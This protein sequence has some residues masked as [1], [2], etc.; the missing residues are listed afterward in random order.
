MYEAYSLE[1]EAGP[2]W[3]LTSALT[4]EPPSLFSK[5]KLWECLDFPDNFP[6]FMCTPGWRG[7]TI[8]NMKRLSFSKTFC[9][10][11]RKMYNLPKKL[12]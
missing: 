4:I 6:A 11:S 7:S 10:L 9:C 5:L 1:F 8:R 2:Y 3:W 12:Q